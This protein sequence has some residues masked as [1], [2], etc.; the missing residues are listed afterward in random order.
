MKKI[1]RN[2]SKLMVFCLFLAIGLF[3]ASNVFA[4][5]KDAKKPG[6]WVEVTVVIESNYKAMLEAYKKG[7]ADGA[8]EFASDNYFNIYDSEEYAM[9]ETI[10][11]NISEDRAAAIEHYFHELIVLVQ[12][13]TPFKD[14]SK[15]V[16][17]CLFLVKAAAKELDA[18]SVALP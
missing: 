11:K 5:A 13:E 9:E 3:S 16:A 8:F 7:D 17:E 15:M 12:D 6:N 4:E 14:V 2:S 18:K 1:I 10:I